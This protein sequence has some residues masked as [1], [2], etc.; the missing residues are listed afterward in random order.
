MWSQGDDEILMDHLLVNQRRETKAS[1]AGQVE[2]LTCECLVGGF[3]HVGARPVA[4]IWKQNELVV[5][6]RN[7][8]LPIC[9]P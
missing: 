6:P 9:G 7:M 2:E 4:P 8:D 3:W 1:E 5:S